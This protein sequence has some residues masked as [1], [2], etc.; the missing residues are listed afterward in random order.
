MDEN[1]T[2][3]LLFLFIINVVI[4]PA[5]LYLF[6]N[7]L[8]YTVAAK[9]LSELILCFILCKTKYISSYLRNG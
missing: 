8:V 7:K 3:S 4:L 1:L 9:Y 2:Y 5:L 6:G